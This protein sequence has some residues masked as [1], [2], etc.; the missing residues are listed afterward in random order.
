MDETAEDS[1][2][3][4]P[5]LGELSGAVHVEEVGG[6]HGRGLGVQEPPPGR[7]D[8]SPRSWRDPQRL[9]DPADRE[10]AGPVALRCTSPVSRSI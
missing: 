10:R 5:L 9:E 6:Q 8:A 1:P 7:I 4:D 3:L 2:A